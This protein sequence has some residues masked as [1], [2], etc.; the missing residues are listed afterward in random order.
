MS[1]V[2]DSQVFDAAVTEAHANDPVDVIGETPVVDTPVDANTAANEIVDN[3]EDEPAPVADPAPSEGDTPVEEELDA[4]G[5]PLVKSTSASTNNEDDPIDEEELAGIDTSVKSIQSI[6]EKSPELKAYAAAHPEFQKT[7][8]YMARKADRAKTYDEMFHSPSFAKNMKIAA[9]EMYKID[10][11]YNG[12][13][14]KAFINALIANSFVYDE[15]GEPRIGANG[16]PEST[17]AYERIAAFWQENWITDV[18][19]HAERLKSTQHEAAQADGEE[20]A[21][22]IEVINRVLYGGKG[23]QASRGGTSTHD[24]KELEGLT[25]ALKQELLDARAARVGAGDADKN[26]LTAFTTKVETAIADTRTTLINGLIDNLIS[27]NPKIVMTDYQ[28][29]SIV[30]DVNEK[31]DA[32]LK[33]DVAHTSS[34]KQFIKLAP[35]NDKGLASIVSSEKAMLREI[36]PRILRSAFEEATSTVVKTAAAK[37]TKIEAGLK[38]KNLPTTGGVKPQTVNRDEKVDKALEAAVTANGG[39]RLSAQQIMDV[40]LEAYHS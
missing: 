33:N 7:L 22:A 20:L 26:S 5:K 1:R 14:P 8:G 6:I 31:L 35:R 40:T 2:S 12:D 36:A 13:D 11:L 17:G 28:R 39:K 19:A 21:S 37:G 18:T 9:D 30:R 4:D 3:V 25:P 27:K 34:F 29:R 16:R 24:D 15:K 23:P 32:K 10:D 38:N